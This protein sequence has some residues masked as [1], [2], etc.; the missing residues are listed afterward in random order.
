M[1]GDGGSGGMAGTGGSGGMAGDGGSGGMAGDGGS[2]GMAGDGGSGGTAGDGGS[3]G[4]GGGL[5]FSITI[6][7][8][9]STD[10]DGNY[11]LAWSATIGSSTWIIQEDD[12][13]NFP[14]P[15]QYISYDTSPPHTYAFTGK[16]DGYYCYRVGSSPNGPF[17]APECVT[18]TRPGVPSVPVITSS[19][20]LNL[21]TVELQW[22]DSD[23]ETLY[24]LEYS[25]DDAS[26]TL[27]TTIAA[28]E[29]H[30]EVNALPPCAT[31]YFRLRAKNAQGYS[32]YS[33]SSQATTDLAAIVNITT[34]S[35]FSSFIPGQYG[36]GCWSAST[37]QGGIGIYDDEDNNVVDNSHLY[38]FAAGSSGWVFPRVNVLDCPTCSAFHLEAGTAYQATATLVLYFKFNTWTSNEHENYIAIHLDADASTA[39]VVDMWGGDMRPWGIA[40]GIAMHNQVNIAS[41]NGTYQL[42]TASQE[43]YFIGNASGYI[44]Q[45][46]A[47]TGFTYDAGISILDMNIPIRRD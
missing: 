46:A 33:G 45:V 8:L 9:P 44:S 15:D 17:S 7:D 39:S 38:D 14:S 5:L 35:G 13:I 6:T 29:T 37:E 21:N 26:Y 41:V 11:T 20:F 10:N 16:G 22:N 47:D 2:G 4:S 32:G 25:F 28:N 27:L 40:P 18:V 43:G 23:T 42:P 1:A 34:P 12:N 24:E 31:T 3:G 30:W 36:I 19:S